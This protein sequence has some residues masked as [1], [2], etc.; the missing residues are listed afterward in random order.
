MGEPWWLISKIDGTPFCC[1]MASSWFKAR[2]I[3]RELTGKEEVSAELV[4]QGGQR[5]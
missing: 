4:F 1:H 3:G 5:R 2:D